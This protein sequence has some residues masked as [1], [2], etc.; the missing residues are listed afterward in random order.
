MIRR[1]LPAATAILLLAGSTPASGQT[2]A[3]PP[4]RAQSSAASS[5][6][7]LLRGMTLDRKIGQLLLVQ[8]TGPVYSRDI[9]A[10]VGTHH[11]GGVIFYARND[12]IRD[13][14]QLR[15][16]MAQLQRAS[17]VPLFTAIDQ[18]G[19]YVDRLAQ[20][21]GRRPSAAAIA[22]ANDPA[23]ADA[24]GVRDSRDLSAL[25][26]NLNLAP[27]VDVGRVAN[28]QLV[29]RTFGDDPQAVTRLA[30]AYL[31]GLQRSGRVFGVLKH[32]P[33]LGGVRIDPHRDLVIVTQTREQLESVDWPPYRKLIA[34]R[35]AYAVM[36]THEVVRALDPSLPAT[37]SQRLITGVLRG[38]MHFDGVVITDSLSMEGITASYPQAQAA[39]MAIRAGADLMIGAAHPRAVAEI[40]ASLKRAIAAGTIKESQIDAAARRAL[41]MKGALGLLRSSS[42]K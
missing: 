30:G 37:L 17:A 5:V 26:F 29:D 21:N 11:V 10:M 1:L 13:A 33:G 15:G 20:L 12:N 14:D 28:P 19:G 25:G 34:S 35:D 32:F 8:F 24:V 27:V 31:Q 9:A 16:V 40:V 41:T 4:S 38:E 22:E 36:V 6:D 7:T 18:E 39:V 3:T 42:D 2:T 23:I